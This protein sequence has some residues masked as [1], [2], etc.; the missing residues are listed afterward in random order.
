M[1]D[2]LDAARGMLAGTIIGLVLMVAILTEMVLNMP[3]LRWALGQVV[4]FANYLGLAY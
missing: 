4:R 3:T 2:D 1:P